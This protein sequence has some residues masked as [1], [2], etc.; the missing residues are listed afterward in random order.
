MLERVSRGQVVLVRDSSG[1]GLALSLMLSLA[2][3][4]PIP[5]AAILL[6]PLVDLAGAS[7]PDRTSPD[8]PPYVPSALVHK[9]GAHYLAGH[10]DDDP[11]VAPLDANL[12]RFPPMLIQAAT[13]DERPRR[14]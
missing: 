10:P 1:A 9:L 7:V 13:G 3:H 12:A 8:A 5:G 11:V 14:R 6:C 2:E 4:R